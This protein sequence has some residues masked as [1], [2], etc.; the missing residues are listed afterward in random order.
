MLGTRILQWGEHSIDLDKPFRRLSYD[1]AIQEFAGISYHDEA[2]ITAKAK[3]LGLD[4]KDFATYDRLANEVWEM[5]VEPHLIE[6]TFITDQPT[7]LT[8]LCRTHA[9]NPERTRR[10][11]L[12]LCRM[13]LGNAY[14]ELNDPDLQ[15]QRFDEQLAE[16][17]AANDQEAGVAGGAIDTDYCTALDYGLPYCGGEGIG[18]DRLVM[19]FTGPQISVTSFFSHHAPR[20]IVSIIPCIGQ[21]ALGVIVT[22]GLLNSGFPE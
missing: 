6:P 14:S 18:I 19:L 15:R 1:D 20:S 11:E 5:V 22:K 2:A 16:A 4:P 17:T 9:D 7:W 12:F 3:E 8:P 13:E 10:F 21:C